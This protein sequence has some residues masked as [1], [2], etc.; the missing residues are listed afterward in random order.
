LAENSCFRNADLASGSFAPR[1]G[2]SDFVIYE[3]DQ[4]W[5]AVAIRVAGMVASE[6]DE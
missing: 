4:F 5:I 6:A 3:A 1:H 2:D